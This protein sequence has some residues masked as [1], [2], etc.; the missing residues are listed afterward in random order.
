MFNNK[1]L[2]KYLFLL[3]ITTFKVVINNIFFEETINFDYK[4]PLAKGEILEGANFLIGDYLFK[5]SSPVLE[6]NDFNK[7]SGGNVYIKIGSSNSFFV[8]WSVEN[9]KN[10]NAGDFLLDLKN[11]IEYLKM[12]NINFSGVFLDLTFDYD[13]FLGNSSIRDEQ[14]DWILTF[15]NELKELDDSYKVILLIKCDNLYKIQSYN[16][17]KSLDLLMKD[18]ENK[19]DGLAFYDSKKLNSLLDFYSSDNFLNSI[20]LYF[21]DLNSN[22]IRYLSK[23][24]TIFTDYINNNFFNLSLDEFEK[25]KNY[26]GVKNYGFFYSNNL[27]KNVSENEINLL[28]KVTNF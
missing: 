24:V 14:L 13:T 10:I 27:F 15:F 4:L 5:N 21:L 26:Y 17:I 9:V 23:D 6:F 8:P 11:K 19:F 28:K 16:F 7:I 18:H 3:L 1:I 2:K 12:L 25:Y 22:G 20:Y